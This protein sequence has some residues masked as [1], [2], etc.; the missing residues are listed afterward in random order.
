MS[1]FRETFTRSDSERLLGYDDSAA[2]YFGGCVLLFICIMWSY[3]FISNFFFQSC[4]SASNSFN[5]KNCQ[6]CQCTLCEEYRKK[7]LKPKI[8]SYQLIFSFRFIG[9]FF[10]LSVLWSIFIY[11]AIHLSHTVH[12]QVFDPFEILEISSIATASAIRKA[13]LRLS[14]LHHPDRNPNDPKSSARFILITKAYESLTD[15]VAKENYK[16]YGNP[17]G[18]S[19]MKIGIGLPKFLISPNYQLVV[20]LFFCFILLILVPGIFIFFYHRQKSFMPSGL[21]IE[22][23]Q[24]CFYHLKEGTRIKALPELIAASTESQELT[25][26][27]PSDNED[28]KPIL[29]CL[30]MQKKKTLCTTPLISRNYALLL[31][32]HQKL[33]HYFTKNLHMDL[34]ILLEKSDLLTLCMIEIAFYKNW[35]LTLQSLIE[36]RR[37]IAQGVD[38]TGL[39]SPYIQIPHSDATLIR[40]CLRSRKSLKDLKSLCEKQSD[41]SIQNFFTNLLPEQIKDVKLFLISIP[42]LTITAKAFVKDEPIIVEGDII[43]IEV[44]LSRQPEEKRLSS[45]I[46]HAP[47]YP[48]FREETWWLLVYEKSTYHLVSYSR[49]K[50]ISG[51]RTETMQFQAGAPGKKMYQCLAMSDDFIGVDTECSFSITVSSAS[52]TSRSIYVHPEDEALDGAPSTLQQFLGTNEKEDNTDYSDNG[53]NEDFTVKKNDVSESISTSLDSL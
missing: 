19:A 52:E 11:M 16:K 7:K 35:F 14:R 26:L 38:L 30:D 44:T 13:Y 33:H 6:T 53:I 8:F 32:H 9:Q 45:L 15:Q 48:I 12:V 4:F 50:S 39:A 20:L 5:K 42:I 28:M 29:S 3:F 25:H 18:P 37:R 36:Y 1:G 17:D 31:A 22:S 46:V 24:M 41:D 2:F 47:L 40:K 23:A 49:I 27:R 51:T 21:R 10:I 43:S 34:N